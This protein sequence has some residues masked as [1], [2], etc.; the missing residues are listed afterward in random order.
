MVVTLNNR[1]GRFI[2]KKN[3][4]CIMNNIR[5]KLILS[6]M[7]FFT[8]FSNAYAIYNVE[9][10]SRYDTNLVV[11]NNQTLEVHKTIY[12]RNVH[13]VGI[14]PGQIEFKIKSDLDGEDV[15]ITQY[16]VKDR[17]GKDIKSQ[18][19]QT[20][21]ETTILLD[22]F[23]PILPGFEHIIKLDYTLEYDDKGIFFK[24]LEVPLKENSRIPVWAGDVSITIPK[25][26]Y[27]TNLDS[28]YNFTLKDNNI[29]LSMESDL[30]NSLS[31]EYSR[32]PITIPN[33]Q[34]SLVFWLIINLIIFSL[35]GF[36]IKKELER[37]K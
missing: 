27:F 18:L 24:T 22:I 25:G 35:L 30:P 29:K 26:Y 33:V 12:L 28:K 23:T 37:R 31:F 1:N 14:V 7:I 3:K 13:D 10:F 9:V 21:D 8:L 16:T 20:E 4:K 11:H 19:S 2:N 5:L 34:G 6:L 17:Y 15:K 36:E 32:L